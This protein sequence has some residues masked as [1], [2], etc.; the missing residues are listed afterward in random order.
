VSV[1]PSPF[2]P[3]S[4]RWLADRLD[5][6]APGE[7]NLF[8]T[9][10]RI[11]GG[12]L[13]AQALAADSHPPLAARLTAKAAELGARLL[14]AFDSPSGARQAAPAWPALRA[15][16]LGRHLGAAGCWSVRPT[17]WQSPWGAA[18]CRP[19]WPT[20]W[21]AGGRQ[22]TLPLSRP[23]LYPTSPLCARDARGR[24][25]CPFRM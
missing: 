1:G 14:P 2:R 17:G 21:E 10:I 24:Q 3:L 15:K 25:A 5:V 19:V 7:V 9:T 4:C 6:S 12:L 13:S 23:C 20:D 22:L 16:G 11:L 18:G 8:E